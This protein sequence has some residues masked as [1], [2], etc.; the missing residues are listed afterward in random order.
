MKKLLLFAIFAWLSTAVLHAQKN[1]Y[2]IDGQEVQHFDGSQ[3]LGKKILDYQV[4]K[5]SDKDIQMITTDANRKAADSIII[6]EVKPAPPKKPAVSSK[7]A[8][9]LYAI[10][11][12]RVT[13][14]DVSKLSLKKI[15]HVTVLNPGSADAIKLF[16]EDGKTHK[17]ILFTTK[18]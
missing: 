5:H 8:P 10:D 12:K 14:N 6:R 7:N 16:G 2:V 18:K 3:L 4:I 13:K 15:T 17:A 1:T 9:M 11:G